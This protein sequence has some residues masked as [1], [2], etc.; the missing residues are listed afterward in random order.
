M[1]QDT[2]PLSPAIL[3]L[4]ARSLA[5]HLSARTGQRVLALSLPTWKGMPFAPPASGSDTRF[6]RRL[7]NRA[8]TGLENEP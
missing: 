7:W 2:P 5:A 6:L 8:Q 4:S 3:C 1:L